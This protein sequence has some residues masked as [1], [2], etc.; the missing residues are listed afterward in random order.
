[1][2]HHTALSDA[3]HAARTLLCSRQVQ[4]M[5]QAFLLARVV[6]QLCFPVV[7]A[8]LLC[9]V[10]L[11]CMCVQAYMCGV[12]VAWPSLGGPCQ[13]LACLFAHMLL[14]CVCVF[15]VVLFC[16]HCTYWH[17]QLPARVLHSSDAC[18]GRTLFA[19]VL[20]SVARA[21]VCLNRCCPCHAS[22]QEWHQLGVANVAPF[23]VGV[24]CAAST[25][26]TESAQGT[27]KASTMR[28]A[29]LPQQ[30]PRHMCFRVCTSLFVWLLSAA[31]AQIA[32][33]WRTQG[34]GVSC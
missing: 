33:Q 5:Q 3:V 26:P 6:V 22:Q 21:V 30:V 32:W 16:Q 31:C 8:M 14:C 23:A 10:A 11:G 17:K 20:S 19:C 34:L 2:V 29:E 13:R 28:C 9:A 12:C 1:M 15:L 24:V 25:C 4:H 27:C 7:C 18:C